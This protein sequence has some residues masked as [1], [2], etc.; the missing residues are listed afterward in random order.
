LLRNALFAIDDAVGV[1]VD[2][3]L[4]VVKVV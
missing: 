1:D 3:S 4:G 2:V